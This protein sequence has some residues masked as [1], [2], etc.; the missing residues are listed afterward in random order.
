M[1]C[2]GDEDELLTEVDWYLS[3]RYEWNHWSAVDW[4]PKNRGEFGG[5]ECQKRQ[6]DPTEEEQKCC[7]CPERK[8]YRLQYVTKRY[9]CCCGIAEV[10]FLEMGEKFVEND[11]F[12][13]FGQKR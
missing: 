1:S 7:H 5:Q 11:F 2:D 13:N 6:K 12:K 10:V 9:Q 3:E 4:M 8:E